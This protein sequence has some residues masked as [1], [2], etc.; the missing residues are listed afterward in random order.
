MQQK[1]VEMHDMRFDSFV[2]CFSIA[3]VNMVKGL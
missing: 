2:K 1:I 3:N